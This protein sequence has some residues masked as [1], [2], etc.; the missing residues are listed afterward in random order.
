MGH[1][2]EQT[3]T[4][5]EKKKI[6]GRI[7][8]ILERIDGISPYEVVMMRHELPCIFLKDAMCMIYEVRPAVC[9]TCTSTDAEHCK[10]IHESGNHRAWLKCYQQIREIFQT[11]HARLVDHYREMG[12]QTDALPLPEAVK[13]YFRHPEPIEAWLLGEIVFNS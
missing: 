13:D 4:D 3:F 5:Q 1:H 9:R 2:V 10:M 7:H 11:V 6:A 8:K 12:C